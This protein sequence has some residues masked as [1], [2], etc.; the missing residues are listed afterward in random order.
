MNKQNNRPPPTGGMRH[1]ALNIENMAACLHF[2]KDLLGMS[3]E[4]QPDPDNIYLC[5]GNDNVAL[6]TSLHP[7][8]REKQ[9]LDHLGFILR[10]PEDVDAWYAFLL[11]NGVEMCSKVKQ[12]RDGARSFYCKDPDGN[13]VQMIYH[14]PISEGQGAR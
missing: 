8:D 4:W 2:Y 6:H 1:I 11:E 12:H 9:A 10:K 3:I 5:S 14:P 7:V 13:V